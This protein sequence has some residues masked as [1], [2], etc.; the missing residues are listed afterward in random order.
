RRGVFLSDGNRFGQGR[1]VAR[2]A[3]LGLWA[4]GLWPLANY[5]KTRGKGYQITE[6][7]GLSYSY[8]VY[9]DLTQLEAWADRCSVVPFGA[10]LPSGRLARRIYSA[11]GPL[12]AAPQAL[13]CALRE[14]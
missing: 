11:L 2:A 3:K 7:D 14:G 5:V 4:A 13:V 9:D 8:S 12:I 6:G 10:T 1:L